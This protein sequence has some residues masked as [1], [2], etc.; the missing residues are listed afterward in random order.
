MTATPTRPALIGFVAQ[1]AARHKSQHS[2]YYKL[3]CA[4]DY[5]VHT[6]AQVCTAGKAKALQIASTSLSAWLRAK[7]VRSYTFGEGGPESDDEVVAFR[8]RAGVRAPSCIP[9]PIRAITHGNTR[10]AA[11]GYAERAAGAA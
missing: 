3:R 8:Y 4:A 5:C 7:A 9:H 10:R 11:T 1:S 6:A 2:N